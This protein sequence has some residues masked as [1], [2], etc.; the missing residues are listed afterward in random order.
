MAINW[1]WWSFEE[2]NKEMQ[3]GKAP[4]DFRQPFQIETS[5]IPRKR[6]VSKV[7]TFGFKAT[8]KW[9]F[10]DFMSAITFGL[11][12][13]RPI[14]E[15]KPPLPDNINDPDDKSQAKI[16]RVEDPE[17]DGDVVTKGYLETGKFTGSWVN[18]EANT[19]TVV[20]GLIT[21]VA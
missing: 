6:L 5:G 2:F 17:E 11:I 7:K 3:K 9:L 16:I 21:S 4:L 18:A 8:A 12:K 10:F 19:V 1:N 20:K 13:Q 14:Q 15:D